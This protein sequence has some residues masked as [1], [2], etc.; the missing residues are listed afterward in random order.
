MTR[1]RSNIRKETLN[2]AKRMSLPSKVESLDCYFSLLK[3]P[4][5][6]PHSSKTSQKISS[7]RN[8]KKYKRSSIACLITVPSVGRGYSRLPTTTRSFCCSD[9][10]KA[11]RSWQ[12]ALSEFY[13]FCTARMQMPPTSLPKR[14]CINF[15]PNANANFKQAS[16]PSLLGGYLKLNPPYLSVAWI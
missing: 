6:S 5:T 8:H 12:K 4:K 7:W 14:C 15:S 3:R 9:T 1:E 11:I 10:A 16:S 13:D 2:P